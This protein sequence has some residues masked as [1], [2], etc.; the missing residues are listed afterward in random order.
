LL[1]WAG[2]LLAAGLVVLCL[3]TQNAGEWLRDYFGNPPV[4]AEH[5]ERGDTAVWFAVALLIAAL[6]VAVL[7]FRERGAGSAGRGLLVGVAVL[8]VVVGV[9]SCVQIYRI[10]D[11]GSQAVWGGVVT[12]E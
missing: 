10:G 4:V 9:A 12:P 2:V 6:A 5:A 8:A 11:S 7:H 3:L 1:W